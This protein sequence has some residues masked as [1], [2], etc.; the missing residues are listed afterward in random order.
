MRRVNHQLVLELPCW[1]HP[2]FNHK[3][4][5][6]SLHHRDSHHGIGLSYIWLLDGNFL[7]VRRRW[8]VEQLWLSYCPPCNWNKYHHWNSYSRCSLAGENNDVDLVVRR[9]NSYS[10]CSTCH[11]SQR[12]HW[13]SDH[14]SRWSRRNPCGGNL[15]PILCKLSGCQLR[16]KLHRQ[17]PFS[18]SECVLNKCRIQLGPQIV[19]IHPIH[20]LPTR[21]CIL[22]WS[23]L[24]LMHHLR[25]HQ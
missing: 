24:N 18:Q 12:Q 17:H 25:R 2:E 15:P 23:S 10:H 4:L 21:L 1:L 22:Y 16:W 9:Y 6:R 8:S 13:H 20:V 14:H 11:R 3:H 19:C 7:V 5:Y